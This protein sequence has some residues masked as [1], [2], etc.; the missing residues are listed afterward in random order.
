MAPGSIDSSE[1][2]RH[3]AEFADPETGRGIGE[4]GQLQDVTVDGTAVT[5]KLG[6]TSHSAILREE[7]K[8]RLTQLLSERLPGVSSVRIELTDFARPPEKIGEIGLTAKSVIAV[9][10]GK[11][12]VGKSTIAASHRPGTDAG[13]LPGRP[14]G[15]RRLRPQHSAPARRQ[16]TARGRRQPHPAD[17]GR[18]V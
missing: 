18:R 2:R 8:Q 16:P 6:L 4:T 12:G 3:L 15:R 1:V 10:S 11:G 13:R 7:T 14:D 17:R 5:V 9:G